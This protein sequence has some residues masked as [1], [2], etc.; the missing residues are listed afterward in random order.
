[1]ADAWLIPCNPFQSQTSLLSN[2]LEKAAE[3]IWELMHMSVKHFFSTPTSGHCVL[4]AQEG[5]ES[6]G[7]GVPVGLAAASLYPSAKSFGWR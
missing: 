2:C 4:V 6:I 1:M 5:W 3:L 7:H